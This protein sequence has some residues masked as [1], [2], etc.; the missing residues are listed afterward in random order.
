MASSRPETAGGALWSKLQGQVV[1]VT[2]ASSGIGREFCLDLAR[3][4]CRVVA[5]ARR[6]DRLCSLC[7][8]INAAAEAPLAVAVELDV[9]AG[10]SFV[11][12][13]VQKAWDAFGRVDVLIN[14]AGVRGGVHSA[15]D[16][17]EDEW[18]KLMKTNLRGVWLVAKH[19]CRRMRDAKLKGS[20]INISSTSGLDG[21]ITHG[22]LAYSASKS[23]VHSVTKLMALELG[24]HGIRVNTIAPGIFKSEIT[25]PLLQKRWLNDVVSKIVPLKKIG[26][27]DPAL[28]SL[29]RF[30]IHE[31]SSYI[32][33]NIF[34]VDSGLV[35]P[36]VPIFSSL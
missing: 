28:T 31:T 9:A 33:G 17:P 8:E 34:V 13:A 36:G 14:N 21:G 6:A 25:A 26:T 1:L 32:S 4:G 11:E 12:A 18:D 2:G 7:D 24:A 27:P 35:L 10:E 20:V 5:A 22:S 29:V 30:L 15:L 19:V 16:W 3:G 23:A